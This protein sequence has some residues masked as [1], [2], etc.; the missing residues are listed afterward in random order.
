[1]EIFYDGL[2]KASQ[3]ATNVVVAGGL[4][5]KMYTEAI[6]ILDMISRN[7]E[8]WEDNG[9]NRFGRRRSNNLRTPEN[10]TVAAL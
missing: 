8:D 7:H 6:D 9:Y 3:T 5:D 1:M 4:L 2:N 10:D